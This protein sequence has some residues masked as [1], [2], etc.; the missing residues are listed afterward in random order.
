MADYI[1]APGKIKADE[2]NALIAAK[3]SG[4][5]MIL[6]YTDRFV[7]APQAEITDIPHLLEARIFT[8]TAEL[9]IMRPTMD[10]EFSYR[11]IDDT[12]L[13]PEHY[14]DEDQFLDID[15]KKSSGTD[16]VTTGGG[17]YTLPIEKARKIRIRNY[18]TYDDQGIAQITD[19]RAV[20]YLGG[21]ADG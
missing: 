19:F 3:I 16:Y 7:C 17:K 15:E 14:I 6:M 4:G 20:K 18:L 12:D 8:D 9:K 5:N 11:L 21:E 10:C 1:K 13:S 2:I